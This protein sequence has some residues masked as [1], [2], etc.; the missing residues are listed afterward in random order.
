MKFVFRFSIF[1]IQIQK[2]VSF[3]FFDYRDSISEV[4]L[5]FVFQFFEI[6]FRY[7]DYNC[8]SDYYGQKPTLSFKILSNIMFLISKFTFNAQF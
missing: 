6:Q 1:E 8:F 7:S 5:I 4:N 3:L 2:L